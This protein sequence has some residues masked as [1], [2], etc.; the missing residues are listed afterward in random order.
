[1]KAIVLAK[2]KKLEDIDAIRTLGGGWVGEEALAIALYSVLRYPDDFEKAL[3]VA[4]NHDGDSDS[5]GAIAGNILGTYLGL[6]GI[7]GK[8]LENLELKDLIIEIA[9]DLFKGGERNTNYEED[10][11][12]LMKYWH[13]RRPG[14]EEW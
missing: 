3:T 12:W 6:S 4:T 7:P 14:T 1:M 5:T 9:D 8:Y 11:D 13:C 10:Q 2:E